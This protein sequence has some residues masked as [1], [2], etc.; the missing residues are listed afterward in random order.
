MVVLGGTSDIAS[1]IVARL[2]DGCAAVVLA[3]R[4]A[5]RLAVAA[6]AARRA[7]AQ[8]TELVVFDAVEIDGAPDVVNACFEAVGP[9][10]VDL[11]VVAVGRLSERSSELDSSRIVD[12]VATTYAWPAIALVR[13]ASLLVER[14]TGH[15]VVL[16][17]VAGVRARRNNFAYG[18]AKA[19]LDAFALGLGEA[20]AGTGVSLQVVRPGFVRTKMTAG[21][22][23]A[24][25]ATTPAAVAE[26]VVRGLVDGD[27]ITWS[28]AVLRWV[29]LVLVHLPGGLW[30]RVSR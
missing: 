12:V 3:G 19:G 13:A 2:A 26:S 11:V 5:E 27:A 30:R 22:H 29:F 15:I 28:P 1:E 4:N 18:S 7:G 20:L 10:G 23:A 6:E 25:L 14:G 8:R 9:Q 16:S 21:L 24:P 17:S